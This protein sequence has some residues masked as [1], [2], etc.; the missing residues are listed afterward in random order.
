MPSPPP[1]PRGGWRLVPY[2]GPS[3]KCPILDYL[4]ELR[5]MDRRRY[6]QFQE[7]LRPMLESRGPFDVGPPYWVG[8]GDSLWE[9]RFG[10][11]R[12]YCSIKDPKQAMMLLG[13]TKFWKKFRPGD[14]ALCL[15]RKADCEN[16]AYDQEQREYLYR[17]L[18][19]RRRENGLA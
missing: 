7:V 3:G 10:R 8:V 17:G 5:R 15:Q 6:L 1:H 4:N 9:I 14:R 11:C 12:I 16:E 18:C 13:A 2:I 19:K